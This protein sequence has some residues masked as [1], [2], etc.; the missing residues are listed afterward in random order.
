MQKRAPSSTTLIFPQVK[1][2]SETRPGKAMSIDNGDQVEIKQTKN[3]LDTAGPA[4]AHFLRTWTN[5]GVA[6]PWH[7][8][9]FS[10]YTFVPSGLNERVMQAV[11]KELPTCRY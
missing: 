4:S 3:A 10:G 8:G 5:V 7:R 11:G 2:A 6:W 1:V 9:L